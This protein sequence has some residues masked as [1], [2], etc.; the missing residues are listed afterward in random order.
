MIFYGY[1][2]EY[3]EQKKL[4]LIYNSFLLKLDR[5]RAETKTDFFGMQCRK[6]D[7]Y[8][9]DSTVLAEEKPILNLSE[10]EKNKILP[11]IT[12][13]FHIYDNEL[14]IIFDQHPF[15]KRY[16]Y[17][18]GIYSPA[19]LLR[20]SESLASENI[21]NDIFANNMIY[22]INNKIIPNNIK[23]DIINAKTV[24]KNKKQK[25]DS[26]NFIFSSVASLN[27]L[28]KVLN[29]FIHAFSSIQPTIEYNI[30]P[31]CGMNEIYLS[32]SDGKG[33]DNIFEKKHVDGPFFFLPYCHVYRCILG[34]SSNNIVSTHFEGSSNKHFI[35]GT[36]IDIYEYVAFDYNTQPHYITYA[37]PNKMDKSDSPR[38]V[39]KL[40]Y[41]IYPKSMPKV[42]VNFYKKI[43]VFYNSL[44][45][46]LFLNSQSNGG[47]LA[48]IINTGND[49]F[50][51]L[52]FSR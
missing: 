6:N 30:E 27:S 47:V 52:L 44:M 45:R 18:H 14:P 49:L 7:S 4:D 26:N 9:K 22:M 37:K 15:P 19:N 3:E 8:Y 24:I 2:Y 38:V 51:K 21:L 50:Y 41:I 34:L 33:S 28:K 29:F 12:K 32:V 10:Q 1:I 20:S 17:S 42:I 39:Y 40:H 25:V 16:I 11:K 31:I 13:T 36:K 35:K 5:G 46:K 48:W 23:S 43:H